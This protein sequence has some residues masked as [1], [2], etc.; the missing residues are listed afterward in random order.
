MA[1]QDRYDGRFLC[2][3]KKMQN[4]RENGKGRG[5]KDLSI[6]TWENSTQTSPRNHSPLLR[7]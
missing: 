7:I 4:L 6:Y 3:E 5:H 1:T 2:G